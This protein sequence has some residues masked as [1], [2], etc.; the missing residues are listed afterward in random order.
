M[1]IVLDASMLVACHNRR[2]T[3]HEAAVALM[4]DVA[5]GAYGQ[6][7]LPEYVF[8]ETVTVLMNRLDPATAAAIGRTLLQTREVDFVPCS[9]LF[10]DAFETFAAPT[11]T[12]LSF[13]D[14]AI[15]TIARRN[16]PPYV[17]TFDRC[18]AAVPGIVAIPHAPPTV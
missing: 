16:D 6:A 18:I 9:E 1:T 7:L 8:L 17:A 3:H 15:V 11:A 13:T 10:V 4:Q 2:D 12:G 5:R 14:A